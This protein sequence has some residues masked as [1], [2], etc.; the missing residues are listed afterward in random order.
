MMWRRRY[1]TNSICPDNNKWTTKNGVRVSTAH[2][3]TGIYNM[4]GGRYEYL[5]GNYSNN[6]GSSGINFSNL[7]KKYYDLYTDSNA[8]L[9]DATTET[10]N[11]NSNYDGFVYSQ[12]SWFMKGVHAYFESGSGLWNYFFA[13]GDAGTII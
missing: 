12:L 3:T 7:N 2:N 6:V 8:L 1:C 4:A 5:M 10:K 13:N 11:W 9:G